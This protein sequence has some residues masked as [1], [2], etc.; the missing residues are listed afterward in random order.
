M[1]CEQN[2]VQDHIITLTAEKSFET[3][4]DINCLGRTIT[5]K[6]CIQDEIACRLN[7]GYWYHSATV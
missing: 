6:I 7:L 2:S 5:N 1:P 4:A 3:V